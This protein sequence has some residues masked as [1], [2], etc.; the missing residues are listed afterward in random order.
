MPPD[1]A[2]EWHV[3]DRAQ[4]FFYV[5]EGRAT[6]RVADE[7]VLLAAGAGIQIPPGTPH[8]M[9]NLSTEAVRFLVISTPT[10]RGDRQSRSRPMEADS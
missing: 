2:E 3:H 10:T 1:T 5:L 4:Q 9:A 6:M 7:K 8:Q